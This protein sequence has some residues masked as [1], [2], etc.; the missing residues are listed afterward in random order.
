MAASQSANLGLPAAPLTD[1][2]ELFY[3][4]LR[5]Y[6]AIRTV[7][8]SVDNNTGAISPPETYWSEVGFTRCTIGNSS[9]IYIQAYENL[10]YGSTVGIYNDGG[11]GKA[12]KA[13]DGVLVCIG[14]CAATDGATAGDY[15]EI[16]LYGLFA[17][18]AAGTLT[19]GAGY[20]QSATAGVI[21]VSGSGAQ[22]VGY[23]LSDTQLFFCPQF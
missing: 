20:Y 22:F 3:E 17:P 21:G 13:K 12:K 2:Q 4:L 6:N 9:K 15:T 10:S 18:F 1:N 7:Q 16:Q 14:F 11:T 5:V 8:Q 23:A 19:P